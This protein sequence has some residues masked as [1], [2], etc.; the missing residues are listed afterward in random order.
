MTEAKTFWRGMLYGGTAACFAEMVTNPNDVLKVRMQLQGQQGKRTY[1]TVLHAAKT[2][3]KEEG[4]AGFAKGIQAAV[5]RQA[6]YGS[7]RIGL[8][9]VAK[10]ALGVKEDAIDPRKIL[11]GVLAGSTSAFLCTPTDV[12]KVRMQAATGTTGHNYRGIRDAF[13]RIRRREGWRGFYKG[14]GPVTIRAGVV[15]AAELSS[16]DEIKGGLKRNTSLKEGVWL[17]L[18]TSMAAGFFSTVVSSPFDVIKSRVITQPIHAETGEPLHYTGMLD[19]LQKSLKSEGP[20]FMW[21]GFWINYL[22]KGPCVV[23]MFM[24]YERIRLFAEGVPEEAVELFDE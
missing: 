24:A 1:N 5:L 18:M 10:R 7:L 17:H 2:I 20:S 21:R 6:T 4:F 9:P 13:W 22:N 23:I 12:I 3:V 8:Y 16:Y 11:A 19:C 14:A 15:A